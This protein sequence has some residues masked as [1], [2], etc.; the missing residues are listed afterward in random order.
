[1]LRQNVVLFLGGL[2]AGIGGFMYHAVA[3]RVLGPAAYGQ[4][5]SLI[6]IYAAGSAPSVVLSVVLARHTA[7]LVATGEGAAIR[8]LVSRMVGLVAIPSVVAV[9][10]AVAI[11][12]P[13]AAFDHLASTFPVVVVGFLLAAAWQVAIP[14]GV[15]QGLQQFTS[16]SLNLSLELVART[17]LVF[18]LLIAGYAVAGALAAVLAGLVLAFTLGLLSLRGHFAIGGMRPHLAKMG[19]FSLTAAAGIVG[20]QIL[21]SQDVIFAEHYL[22]SHY[23]GIYGG[24]N[25]IASIVYFLTLSVSQVL[26]PRIVEATAKRQHP[27]RI[28]LASATL[29]AL[30]GGCAVVVFGVIPQVVVGVLFGPGFKDAIPYVLAAGL[31]GLAL[32]LDNLLVQFLMGVH[33]RLFIAVLGC[34]CIV[35]AGLIAGFHAGVGQIIVDV[36]IA[37]TALLAA[38]SLR[39]L[40]LLLSTSPRGDLESAVQAPTPVQ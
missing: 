40:L 33:D 22:T 29:L 37:T 34:G 1:L 24:L 21:Y 2:V 19:A 7:R 12:H 16:L 3:G 20:I 35:E 14:R 18:G 26:F 9:L 11:Q 4:L 8:A 5:A 38:L 30:L 32:A 36:L 39:C 27:G 15:L 28:L 17:V 31:I 10:V 6:A 25:K 13:I 23:G